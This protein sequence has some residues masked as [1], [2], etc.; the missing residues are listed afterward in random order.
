MHVSPAATVSA[1][2]GS[3]ES[4]VAIPRTQ[5]YAVSTVRGQQSDY[6]HVRSDFAAQAQGSGY[7]M[8]AA[9]FYES[10]PFHFILD[11]DCRVLQVNGPS[12]PTCHYD[13]LPSS[14]PWDGVVDYI[15][16]ESSNQSTTVGL[17]V[18]DTCAPWAAATPTGFKFKK[19]MH[20][21][22]C[23]QLLSSSVQH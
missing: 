14:L 6:L 13:S 1:P 23:I 18:L 19:N 5:V 20:G 4:L 2:A 7:T 8:D 17:E 15:A 12:P 21:L 3:L 16:L 11:A 9:T 10:F 22:R